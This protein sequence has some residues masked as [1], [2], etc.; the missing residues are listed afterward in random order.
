MSI[1]DKPGKLSLKLSFEE[2]QHTQKSFGQPTNP[3][4]APRSVCSLDDEMGDHGYK[5]SGEDFIC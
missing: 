1:K 5:S 4:Q 2:N 3:S